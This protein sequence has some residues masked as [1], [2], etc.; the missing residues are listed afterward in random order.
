MSTRR[1]GVMRWCLVLLAAVYLG[2]CQ[3]SAVKIASCVQTEP[4][5]S[6]GDAADDAA[7]WVNPA[8]PAASIVI[9]T[10]K[11]AG[12]HVY[13]LSGRELQF[14]PLGET[15]NV[16]L[17]P[18]FPFVDGAAPIIAT[19]N[20]TTGTVVLLRFDPHQRRIVP[21]PV[22]EIPHEPRTYGVCLYRAADGTV[23][24]GATVDGG[25]FSQW[26]LEIGNS[27]EIGS[28]LVRQISFASPAEGC[29]FDHQLGRLYIGEEERGIWRFAAD[30]ARGDDG[31]LVDEVGWLWDFPNEVEG[32]DI[33]ALDDGSGYLIASNQGNSTFRLYRRD[34]NEYLGRFEV[35]GCSE[36]D[37]GNVTD[38]DGIAVVSASLGARWPAG[39]LVV[40]DGRDGGR[41]RRQNF[42][43]VS[44]S[45]VARKMELKGRQSAN[46]R[47]R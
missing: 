24:V 17:L 38:T 40:Q 32:L 37:T 46:D 28:K 36:S 10:D 35:V 42:R 6:R 2:G 29:V 16:D 39:L 47:G 22:A 34:D 41:K 23:H 30:P 25:P 21:E 20:R 27:G 14:I 11:Q 12:L 5:R 3:L 19:T 33:Y 7:I 8:D 45:E 18:D 9:G 15:N 13:D 31:V 4:V 1:R 26:R 44:W 43:Y